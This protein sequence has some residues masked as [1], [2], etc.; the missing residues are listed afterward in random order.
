MPQR[1]PDHKPSDDALTG[2]MNRERFH[3]C[4]TDRLDRVA[5]DGL[6]FALLYL[7]LDRLAVINETF[8]HRVGD[9]VLVEV[10]DRLRGALRAE[11]VVGRIG[12]DEFAVLQISAAS[13]P[14]SSA[15]L[16]QRLIEALTVPV[17]IAG[18]LIEIELSIG[19]VI[20]PTD[21][22]DSQ[23]IMKRAALAL[24]RAK[25]DGRNTRRFYEPLMDAA[26]EARR[27]LEIDLRGALTRGEFEVHYQPLVDASSGR[28]KGAEA[29]VR[30]RH[31]HKGLVSPADFIALAEETGQIVQLGE[32][33]LRTACRDWSAPIEVVR[34]LVWLLSLEDGR[35]GKIPEARG[36]RR[37]AT[38]GGRADL[39]GP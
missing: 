20:A 12:G 26:A 30:W 3:D 13:Q 18:E 21:G 38:S 36:D 2:L 10:A 34:P 23:M 4:L 17:R 35:D 27:S 29:L 28:P 32:W 22:R 19:I 6:P 8:G 5:R 39:T 37:E 9:A 33:V 14:A 15:A 25:T 16:A 7:D 31:P 1:S 11:D 24:S